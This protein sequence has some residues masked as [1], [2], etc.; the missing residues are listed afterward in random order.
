V[1][2]L[3]QGV[4]FALTAAPASIICAMLFVLQLL[5]RKIQKI[6]RLRTA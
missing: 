1:M 5:H 6:F 2:L 4:P 3:A